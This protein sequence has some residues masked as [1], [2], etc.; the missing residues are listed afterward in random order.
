MLGVEITFDACTS[1]GSGCASPSCL[2]PYHLSL[3]LHATDVTQTTS[4]PSC[5]VIGLTNNQISQ[6]FGGGEG[7]C[8]YC[9][10]TVDLRSTSARGPCA[11]ART[12]Y[13]WQKV[14][15]RQCHHCCIDGVFQLLCVSMVVCAHTGI[16]ICRHQLVSVTMTSRQIP[17]ASP[18]PSTS[19]WHSVFMV[20][21]ILPD[22]REARKQTQSKPK[23]G[24][25]CVLTNLLVG[26]GSDFAVSGLLERGD[27]SLCWVQPTCFG[28]LAG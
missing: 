19:P 8:R 14:D 2:P 11:S 26:K 12:P 22:S 28:G 18:M 13:I 3:A 16:Y 15:F 6:I 20:W 17:Y 7:T 10:R 27:R 23:A 1:W 9:K 4:C 25:H 21:S 5:R 24:L